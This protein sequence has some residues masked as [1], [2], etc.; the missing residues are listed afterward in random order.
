MT[1][2]RL[3]TIIVNLDADERE[4]LLDKILAELTIAE[5]TDA[6]TYLWDRREPKTWSA[7]ERRWISPGATVGARC[8]EAVREYQTEVARID[9]QCAEESES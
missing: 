1:P 3:D 9:A 2:A 8:A 6:L 7:E 4:V 5:I